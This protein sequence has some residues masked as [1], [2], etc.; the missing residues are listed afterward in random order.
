MD[1]PAQV[2]SSLTRC[3]QVVL[4]ISC[5]ESQR[6]QARAHAIRNKWSRRRSGSYK[7][8]W[9]CWACWR[10]S[11]RR[12]AVSSRTSTSEVVVGRVALMI[13]ATASATRSVSNENRLFVLGRCIRTTKLHL[14]ILT[15]D[16]L[17]KLNNDLDH[18]QADAIELSDTANIIC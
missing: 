18:V 4:R 6:A 14:K 13:M 2:W 8:C 12:R 9:L 15:G 11:L 3:W 7:M 5:A 16:A 17:A 1:N 10:K